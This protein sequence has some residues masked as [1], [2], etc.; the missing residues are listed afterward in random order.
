MTVSRWKKAAWIAKQMDENVDDVYDFLLGNLTRPY[1][2][3]MEVETLS[4]EY[5]SLYADG[6]RKA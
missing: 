3:Y 2:I 4:K 6:M 1:E 5:D